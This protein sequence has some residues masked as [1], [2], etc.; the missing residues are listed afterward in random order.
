MITVYLGL[1]TNLGDRLGNLQ[2]AADALA[3]AV[4][5]LA[6]SPVYE[7]APLYVTA[8]PAFLN[9]ALQGAT[10]LPPAALLKALKALEAAM[11]RAKS[12]RNGPR[13]ID[14][15]ILFYGSQV[16][17]EDDLVI[18]HPAMAERHFVMIPLA[19]IAADLVHPVSGRKVAELHAALPPTAD[20]RLFAPPIR[21]P[22]AAI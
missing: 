6:C 18:P 11:G 3:P 9:M 10:E 14:L 1:G 19:D 22:A 16:V 5:V 7:T 4:T 21:R 8:Q 12:E 20:V 2:R 13:L 15:D 17:A